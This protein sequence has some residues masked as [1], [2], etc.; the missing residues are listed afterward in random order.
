MENVVSAMSTSI[1]AANLWTEIGHAVPLIAIG[2]LF[3]L[4]F[5][6]V[7]RAV[8]GISKHKTNMQFLK[9]ICKLKNSAIFY[10]VIFFLEVFMYDVLVS[11]L[12]SLVPLVL[13]IISL[14]I[15]LDWFADLVFGRRY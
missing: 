4:G 12:L 6:V 13:P 11:Y 9:F 14:R 10:C 2:V 3:S 8:K 7:K 1:S 15:V 5:Y